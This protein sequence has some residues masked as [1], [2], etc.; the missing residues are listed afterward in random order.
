ML[1]TALSTINTLFQMKLGIV[2]NIMLN[3]LFQ[4]DTLFQTWQLMSSEHRSTPGLSSDTEIAE[5][6]LYRVLILNDDYSPM[7]FVVYVL[8]H[9]FGHDETSANKIMLDVHHQGAGTAGV[10][11]FEIAETSRSSECIFKTKQVSFE[12]HN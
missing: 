6:A 11:S 7:D 8:K 4:N 9:F 1:A 10:Y 3:K 5:P 12:M 2:V